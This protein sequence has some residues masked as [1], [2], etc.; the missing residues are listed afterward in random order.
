MGA[1]HWRD[2]L[3]ALA[4]VIGVDGLGI[5]KYLGLSQA[6]IRKQIDDN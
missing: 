4:M 1:D 5:T 3:A 2:R 6:G